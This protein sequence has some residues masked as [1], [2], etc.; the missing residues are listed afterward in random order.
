MRNA[1]TVLTAVAIVVAGS[2][3][4][5][6]EKKAFNLS[7]LQ[8]PELCKCEFLECAWSTTR[9]QPIG[10]NKL[11]YSYNPSN[12]DYGIRTIRCDDLSYE[13][14]MATGCSSCINN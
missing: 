12:V 10:G 5:A 11:L 13:A 2:S 4:L 3:A 9:V 1:M 6:G 14:C 8:A 7:C